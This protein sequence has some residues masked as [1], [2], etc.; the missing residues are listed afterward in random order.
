MLITS[1]Q[2]LNKIIAQSL[3]WVE[4]IHYESQ[5]EPIP[6][7]EIEYYHP[8]DLS[9]DEAEEWF[10]NWGVAPDFSEDW[11]CVEQWILPEC[12]RLNLLIEW[13]RSPKVIRCMICASSENRYPGVM[14]FTG[15]GFK[16]PRSMPLATCLAWLS[17]K[18]VEF[19]LEL[20]DEINPETI[21]S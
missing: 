9:E 15:A 2:D 21:A 11:Y 3:G 20:P 14:I 10:S 13:Q 5:S 7:V 19:K 18:G 4:S 1:Y 16:Y 6:D 12:D 17:F 8:P